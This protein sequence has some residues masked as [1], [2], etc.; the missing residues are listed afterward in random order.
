MSDM[1]NAAPVTPQKPA[2]KMRRPAVRLFLV[3]GVIILAVGFLLVKGLGS[4]LDYFKTV[5]QAVSQ[6]QSIG[7]SEIR[8]QGTVVP[9]SV[10]RTD[11]GATF[12]VAGGTKQVYVV[13]SGT[14]PQLFK[15]SMPVVVVG[16]FQSSESATFV[17]NQIMVKHTSSYIESHPERVKAPD[18]TVH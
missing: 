15:G 5:D 8:L 4:S 12:Q 11:T 18:G 9:G 13:N 16:H 2:K 17:S 14:P 1:Q 3:G 10:T 6:K 7:T